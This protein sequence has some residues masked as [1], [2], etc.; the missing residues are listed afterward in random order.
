MKAITLTAYAGDFNQQRA[1]QAGFQQYVSK[2]VE[3]EALVRAI[4]ALLTG[5]NPLHD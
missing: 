3:P 1:L 2:P 5:Q 4:Q